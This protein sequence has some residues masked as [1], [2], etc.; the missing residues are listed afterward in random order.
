MTSAQIAR[1]L[2][3]DDAH[4]RAYAK[5]GMAY[6]VANCVFVSID[7]AEA[8]L[9]AAARNDDCFDI[10]NLLFFA[11]TTRERRKVDQVLAHAVLDAWMFAD[12]LTG[13]SGDVHIDHRTA[14]NKECPVSD[15][16]VY[17]SPVSDIKAS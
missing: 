7:S 1:T 11:D 6:H 10:F 5:L 16:D 3:G 12:I 9:I 14:K 4:L 8:R 2:G 17:L 13:D 15:I